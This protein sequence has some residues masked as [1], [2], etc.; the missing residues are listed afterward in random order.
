MLPRELPREI[1]GNRSKLRL[2]D[3][4]R[5]TEETL[6]RED[7]SGAPRKFVLDDC[8]EEVGP[9]D[10]DLQSQSEEL[11]RGEGTPE[12]TKDK[13]GEEGATEEP[14]E[15]L[16]DDVITSLKTSLGSHAI[17]SSVLCE[18]VSN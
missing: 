10:G 6:S 2:E 14:R 13:H 11:R 9:G 18:R 4:W 8:H 16:A 1:D 15:G 17:V 3:D 12:K 7:V 5:E